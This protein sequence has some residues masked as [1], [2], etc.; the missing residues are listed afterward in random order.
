MMIVLMVNEIGAIDDDLGFLEEESRAISDSS[1]E[2]MVCNFVRGI[3]CYV[4]DI[5]VPGCLQCTLLHL[6]ILVSLGDFLFCDREYEDVLLE[7]QRYRED[8]ERRG[9]NH[10]VD[11]V[12][13]LSMVLV[14]H[15]VRRS[16]VDLEQQK[17]GPLWL[18]L[19]ST[20]LSNQ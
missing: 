13:V 7:I 8:V 14:L 9:L 10:G 6:L 18:G 20:R 4:I 11:V 3:L 5:Q 2:L 12:V 16:G 17:K 1:V 15:A 19:D